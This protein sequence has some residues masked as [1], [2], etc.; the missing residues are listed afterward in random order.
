AAHIDIDNASA[1]ATQLTSV[2]T[3]GAGANITFDQTGGGALTLTSVTT[4]DGTIDIS[5]DSGNIIATLVTAGANGDIL[6]NTTTSGDITLGSLTAAGDKITINS[7]GAIDDAAADAIADLTASELDLD[8]VDGI[9]AGA[10][11][12]TVATIIDADTT[13]NAAHIDIDNASASATQLTSVSTTGA[14]ANITFDQ[15]GGGPLTLTSVTTADG[16]INISADSGNIIATLVTAGANGD[17]LLDTTTS[18]DIT[19]GALTAAGDKITINS[20]GAIDDA[21]A[22]TI[23]DLTA[24]ELDLDA[25]DGIGAGAAIETVATIIDADTT[26]NAAHIDIDNASA[27]AT[28]LT[29]VSTTGAGANITVDQTGGGAL[30]LT[31]VTTTDGTINISADSGN[32]IATLATA[33]ANGDILLDTTTSGDITLGSLTAGNAISLE[34]TAGTITQGLLGLITANGGSLTLKS[35]GDLNAA[36]YTVANRAGTDLTLDSTGGSAIVTNSA[37]DDWHS[38]TATAQHNVILSGDGDITTGNLESRD[39]SGL[40][41]VQVFTDTGSGGSLNAQGTILSGGFVTVDVEGQAG[42]AQPVSAGGNIDL[43]TGSDLIANAMSSTGGNIEMTSN[44]GNLEINGNLTA[45]SGGV[46]LIAPAGKIYTSG[47]ANDTLNVEITGHADATK[48]VPLPYGAGT[49]GIVISSKENL[50]V[51]E[52]AVLTANGTYSLAVDDRSGVGFDTSPSEGGDPIDVAIYLGSYRPTPTPTG[53]GVTVDSRVSMADN[54][55]MVVDAYDTVTLGG[56]FNESVFNQITR[57]EVV[58]RISTTLNE[59]ITY[60]RL[61]YADDPEAIRSWFTSPG[62]FTGAYVLRGVRVLFAEILALTNPVPLAPPKPLEPEVSGEVEGPDTEALVN[63]LNELGIGVQPY[64]TEAYAASLS[65]DLRLYSAA[66]KLQQ[67]IPVLEDADG[68]H[69]AGLKAAT[70]QFFPTLDVL[71]EEQMD[72]FAQELVR[73]K[74]DATDLDRAG[75]C[76]FA[77]TEY[78]NILAND[79]GWPVEKSVGFVMSRYVPRLAEGDEIRIAVIQ[80]QLQKTSGV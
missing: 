38:I 75:Q 70:A 67:L 68:T 76:I 46:S 21:A 72:S 28:Q 60:G 80:M 56:K 35:E 58:S 40:N 27:S 42:F 16:T 19:L 33:G 31:S 65:T 44:S 54:G 12:E 43:E 74:G 14:G 30:T 15:T 20:A 50:I 51:G 41:G 39:G 26:G 17:I 2:S 24:S 45:N 22:D 23:A 69:V 77:L 71:S 73:H 8:A 48:G 78:V 32:I 52:G 62:S 5:A 34:A 53:G 25:V 37:A 9:G 63:L 18:G 1:S 47:G 29:S 57:L 49:A 64:V 79:I 6:L 7:A 11:I 4:A 10:A 61:P 36:N 3:T 59:V 55:T 13:G 66:E